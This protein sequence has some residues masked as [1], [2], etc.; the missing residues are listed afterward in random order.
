MAPKP[1]KPAPPDPP[2]RLTPAQLIADIGLRREKIAALAALFEY[3]YPDYPLDDYIAGQPF[4]GWLRYF[5]YDLIVE[6]MEEKAK[7]T[8]EWRDILPI[9]SIS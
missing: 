3:S 2:K 7:R 4:M 6:V 9:S 8:D 5:D 1:T